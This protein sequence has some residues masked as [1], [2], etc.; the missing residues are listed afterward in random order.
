MTGCSPA[1]KKIQAA[2]WSDTAVVLATVMLSAYGR[3][4]DGSTHP[5]QGPAPNRTVLSKGTQ[6]ISQSHKAP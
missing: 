2:A 3:L 5:Q 6:E 1:P 4:W